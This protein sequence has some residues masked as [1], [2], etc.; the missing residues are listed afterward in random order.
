MTRE[1]EPDDDEQGPPEPTG[2]VG[3]TGAGVL[4]VFALVGLVLGWLLRPV[5]TRV[6]GVAPTVGWLPVLTLVF[7]AL[8]LGSVAW[9]TYR[10]LHRRGERIEPHK[11]VNR[12]VLAKSCA[13]A[14]ALVGGGYLGYALS[15]FGV[16]GPE[17]AQQRMVRSLVGGLAGALIVVAS[18]LLEHACRVHDDTDPRQRR[19]LS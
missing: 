17:L 12:L 7:V 8:L 9:A 2:H 13:L 1:L 14:G 15:W 11:A 5:G 3:S 10:S 18:L 16:E 6:N 4:T 19:G